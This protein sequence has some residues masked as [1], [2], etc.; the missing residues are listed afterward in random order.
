MGRCGVDT[1]GGARR[2]D[3]FWISSLCGGIWRTRPISA[4]GPLALSKEDAAAPISNDF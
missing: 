1:G 2:R 4:G 3:E